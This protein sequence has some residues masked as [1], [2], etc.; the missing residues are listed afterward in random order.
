MVP[1]NPARGVWDEVASY[2][3]VDRVYK[4]INMPSKDSPQMEWLLTKRSQAPSNL[5]QAGPQAG[6]QR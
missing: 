1:K 4:F 5:C 6:Q 2:L 3:S